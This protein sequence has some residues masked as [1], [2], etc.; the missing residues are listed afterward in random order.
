MPPDSKETKLGSNNQKSAQSVVKSTG[1]LLVP[2]RTRKF[3]SKAISGGV[4]IPKV[5]GCRFLWQMSSQWDSQK[6][7]Q[8]TVSYELTDFLS[9]F[10]LFLWLN[11]MAVLL[12]VYKLYNFESRNSLSLSF[13]YT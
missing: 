2:C 8:V 5:P 3:V 7:L 10:Y 9:V 13:T 6:L 1:I 4:D 12:E 11:E